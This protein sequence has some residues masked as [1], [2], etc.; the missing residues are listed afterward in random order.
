MS[1][2]HVTNT[3]ERIGEVG[4]TI[5]QLDPV[6]APHRVDQLSGGH[7]HGRPERGDSI[8]GVGR[9]GEQIQTGSPRGRS[10]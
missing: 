8:G 4:L 1:P 9:V 6:V 2:A 5:L 10:G 7:P 3:H